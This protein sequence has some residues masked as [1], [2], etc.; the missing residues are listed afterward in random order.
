MYAP[1]NHKLSLTGDGTA[2][3]KS[4]LFAQIEALHGHP[5]TME[6]TYIGLYGTCSFLPKFEPG[7]FYETHETGYSLQLG[8]G[9]TCRYF[10]L[11][12][13]LPKPTRAR[14]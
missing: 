3:Y 13:R 11:Y 12:P 8:V 5:F 4:D 9:Q 14:H 10:L 1:V 2:Y 7:T 6:T